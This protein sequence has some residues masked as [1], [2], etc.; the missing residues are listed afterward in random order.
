MQMIHKFD[1]IATMKM[2]EHMNTDKFNLKK[3]DEADKNKLDNKFV[4]EKKYVTIQK[5]KNEANKNILENKHNLTH[6]F[7]PEWNDDADYSKLGN[8]SFLRTKTSNPIKI[9]LTNSAYNFDDRKIYEHDNHYTDENYSMQ[10]HPNDD[11]NIDYLNKNDD[12]NDDHISKK[13]GDNQN[14][15]NEQYNQDKDHFSTK[16][17]NNIFDTP[18]GDINQFYETNNEDNVIRKIYD[19]GDQH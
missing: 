12:D 2:I 13:D 14:Y 17:D 10:K 16:N 15:Y 7:N 1:N 11:D 9:C 4:K 5:T 3:K 6:Y 18:N 19:G 8:D